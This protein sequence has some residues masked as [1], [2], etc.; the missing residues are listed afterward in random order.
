MIAKE[1]KNLVFNELVKGFKGQDLK[2]LLLFAW[3]ELQ[4][5]NLSLLCV[6]LVLVAFT[7]QFDTWQ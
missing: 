5:D 2:D 4:V 6:L 7:K 3:N 1:W